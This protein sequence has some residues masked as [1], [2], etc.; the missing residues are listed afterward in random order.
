MFYKLFQLEKTS[1][2]YSQHLNNKICTFYNIG[3]KML[4]TFV[5]KI[6]WNIQFIY[7]IYVV[8]QF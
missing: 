8:K 2:F 4:V 5:F 6:V 7:S 3:K 1:S